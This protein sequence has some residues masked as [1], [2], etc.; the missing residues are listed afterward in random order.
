[1][2][3]YHPDTGYWESAHGNLFTEKRWAEADEQKPFVKRHADQGGWAEEILPP[4][5]GWAEHENTNVPNGGLGSKHDPSARNYAEGAPR[6]DGSSVT[7]SKT[8]F[9]GLAEESDAF[10]ADM[11]TTRQ[12][13]LKASLG[14][15]KPIQDMLTRMYGPG[16]EFDFSAF[17]NPAMTPAQQ[18]Q[19]EKKA[20][21]DQANWEYG[22]E[23]GREETLGQYTDHVKSLEQDLF[24]GATVACQICGADQGDRMH[25]DTADP[26]YHGF[27]GPDTPVTAGSPSSVLNDLPGTGGFKPMPLGPMV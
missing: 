25:K 24:S 2:A 8:Q 4:Q 5:P 1:M 15:F 3:K 7:G 21:A 16:F 18:R 11:D 22:E 13:N 20:A 26:N 23:K 9:G 6:K 17:M 10:L 14:L 12:Q 27:V 19:A